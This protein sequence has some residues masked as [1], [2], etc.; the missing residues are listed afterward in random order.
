MSGEYAPVVED[1]EDTH[2]CDRGREKENPDLHTVGEAVSLCV[3][4]ETVETTGGKVQ[5]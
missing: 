4:F 5:S 3:C 2:G 1:G